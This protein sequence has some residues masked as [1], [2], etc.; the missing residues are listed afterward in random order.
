MSRLEYIILSGMTA[1][2]LVILAAAGRFAPQITPDTAG[3]LSIVG[4]PALL[5]QPRTPLYGWLVTALDLGR[6]GHVLVPAFQISSYVAACWLF[7]AQLRGYGLSRVASLSVGAALL[8]ANAVLMMSNCIH[9][10]LPAITC[11]LLAFAGT[12]HL[13]GPQPRWWGWLLVCVGAAGAYILRP[14]FLPLIVVL[15]VLF[16]SLQAVCGD[17]L[18]PVRAAAIFLVSACPFIGIASLRAAIVGDPNIVSFGGYVMSGMATLMLSDDVVARLPD[19]IKPFAAEVLAA[20]RAGEDSGRMIGIPLNASKV[21]SYSSVAL[22]YFDVLARTHDD[23]LTITEASR[24]PN[25]SWVDLNRR[26]MRFSLAVLRAAP[27]R[28][29]MWVIGAS[30]RMVGRSVVTNL[31]AMLAILIVAVALPWRLFVNRQV[32]VTPASRLDVP[33]MIICAFLWLAAA[34]SLTVLIHAPATRFI[35]TSSLL[36]APALIYWAVLL[37][38]SRFDGSVEEIS[39]DRRSQNLRCAARL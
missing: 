18:G 33:I 1:L 9:P 38:M 37:L 36:V 27:D 5:A 25:E 29:A 30:T 20:R 22:A 17:P 10:E 13:T 31:P 2:S 14:S 32:G 3:Y 35:E 11:A 24:R 4:F 26:L 16:L 15:P 7:V 23:M 34:G 28:Y 21:R 12:V 19:D 39:F 8:C 6:G